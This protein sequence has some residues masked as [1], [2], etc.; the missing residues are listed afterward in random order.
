MIVRNCFLIRKFLIICSACLF[1]LGLQAQSKDRIVITEADQLPRVSYPFEG[2]AVDLVNDSNQ[3][4]PYLEKL[5]KEITDQLLKYDIQ[6]DSTLKA[7]MQTL[8]TLDFLNANLDGALEKIMS[9]REMQDKP[10]DKL[11]FGLIVEAL[12]SVLAEAEERTSEETSARFEQVFGE[13]LN[14]LPWELVQ[15]SI[16][17]MNGT[18]QFLTR[19]LYLGSLENQ[20]QVTIDENKELTLGDVQSLASIVLMMDHVLPYAPQIV[21]VSGNYIEANR[22]V[23]EDIWERRNIDL[24]GEENLSPV[25]IAIW[26][27]GV[28]MEIFKTT[29]QAWINTGESLDGQDNDENGWVDDLHG[30]AWDK[31]ANPERSLLYPLTRDEEEI[32]PK[33]RAYSKGLSDL[34]A[35][36]DSDEAKEIKNIISNLSQDDYKPFFESLSLFGNYMH[37]THVAGIAAEGNP[38]ARILSARLTFG[39]EMIPDKPTLELAIRES[40]SMLSTVQYFRESGV[41]VVNMSWGGNQSAIEAALEANGVGDNPEQRAK[42]ARILFEIGYDSLVEAMAG[43]PEILFI[44]AAGNSDVDVDFTKDIPASIDLPNVMVAGA[45]DQAGDETSFT[46]YGKNVKSHASGF[47]VDSYV[48]GGTRMKSSGTSMAAPNVANLAGKLL[49]IKPD[50]SPLEVK[51]LIELSV[52]KSED[53]RRFLINP[54]RAISMLR[55][56]PEK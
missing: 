33:N 15:D 24:S 56:K 37:G 49:A 46:S 6:D 22:V 50:L 21:S 12:I 34:Q 7:Y 11:T 51:Q 54:Q 16:E 5:G 31:Y 8:R 55:L 25:V 2:K 10:A 13:L 32:Y 48:P 40:E 20:M 9:I 44:A 29:G 52:D 41:R 35:A 53:G 26:D 14:P 39:H 18:F 38:A 17:Q 42:I 27:S 1:T 19:N 45:V 30:I 43:A 23:K 47:E 3:L 4:S 36:I 28:D